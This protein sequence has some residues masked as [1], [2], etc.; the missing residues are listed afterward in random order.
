MGCVH[1]LLVATHTQN[2]NCCSIYVPSLQSTFSL[3]L[4]YLCVRPKAD[5]RSLTGLILQRV[6]K[7]QTTILFSHL[8]P[9]LYS[10][11]IF[12]CFLS[13]SISMLHI[14]FFP[15]LFSFPTL[16]PLTLT[17][18]KWY[19]TKITYFMSMF[20]CPNIVVYARSTHSMCEL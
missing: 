4:M 8:F 10:F 13:H 2:A 14:S 15:F 12:L 11:I 5:S 19:E 17:Q 18:K 6:M 1:L 3:M 7:E 9:L 20:H 16:N